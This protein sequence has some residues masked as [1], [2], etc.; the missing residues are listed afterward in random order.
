MLSAVVLVSVS[1]IRV[2]ECLLP[3]ETVLLRGEEDD[4]DDDVDT[5]LWKSR[6]HDGVL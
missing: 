2:S 5:F 4:E 3:L 1:T 6:Y